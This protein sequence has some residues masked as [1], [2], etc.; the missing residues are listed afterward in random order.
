MNV[1]G[2]V[3]EQA[4]FYE[5]PHP[6]NPIVGCEYTVDG[7]ITNIW[8]EEVPMSIEIGD[9]LRFESKFFAFP[10]PFNRG[11]LVC[12]AGDSELG[13]VHTSQAEWSDFLERVRNGLYVDSSDIC[14]TVEFLHERGEI[15]HGHP[16]PLTL[17]KVV[18][19]P[20][21]QEWELM[22]YAGELLNGN[23]TLDYFLSLYDKNRERHS[24]EKSRG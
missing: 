16:N 9:L 10:N 20:D 18:D 11:D 2:S 19:W 23:G 13:V 15:F 21:K 3:E 1:S 12:V 4:E 24:A 17:E 8:S 14:I 22:K 6:E 7:E 5:D